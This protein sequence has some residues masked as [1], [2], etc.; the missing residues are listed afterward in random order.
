MKS[1]DLRDIEEDLLAFSQRSHEWVEKEGRR[2]M[3]LASEKYGPDR[4]PHRSAPPLGLC[5]AGL[6]WGRAR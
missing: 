2:V 1:H 4:F 3:R 6:R 5:W